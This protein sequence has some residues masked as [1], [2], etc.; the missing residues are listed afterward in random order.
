MR[1]I[2]N[3]TALA[4]FITF[5]VVY[6]L[7]FMLNKY[8]IFDWIR[9]PVYS[10]NDTPPWYFIH[11][12]MAAAISFMAGLVIILTITFLFRKRDQ[13]GAAFVAGQALLWMGYPAFFG[14]IILFNTRHLFNPETAT[15]HWNTNEALLNSYTVFIIIYIMLWLVFSIIWRKRQKKFLGKLAN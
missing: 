15:S 4:L 9:F 11:Q 6:L 13:I 2:P 14:F 5:L 7:C 1:Y 3:K 8:F 10:P 12:R